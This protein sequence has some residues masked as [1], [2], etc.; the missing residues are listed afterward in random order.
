MVS[1]SIRDVVHP[2]GVKGM[3]GIADTPEDFVREVEARL[4]PAPREWLARVD[5][6]L[7]TMSW[8]LTWGRMKALMDRAAEARAPAS[9]AMAEASAP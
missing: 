9:G 2:Y 7:A 4:A 8:D 5:A 6:H 1:T 3:V